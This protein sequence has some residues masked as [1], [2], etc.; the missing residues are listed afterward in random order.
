MLSYLLSSCLFAFAVFKDKDSWHGVA[1]IAFSLNALR[2]LGR[3]SSTFAGQ[4]WLAGLNDNLYF[5]AVATI[6]LLLFAWFLHLARC[7]RTKPAGIADLKKVFRIIHVR[8]NI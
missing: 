5:P 1:M 6:N 7:A 4:T 8:S 2:L 3:I